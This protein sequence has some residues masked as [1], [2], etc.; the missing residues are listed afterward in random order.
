MLICSVVDGDIGLNMDGAI[1]QD[2]QLLRRI[3]I[4][5]SESATL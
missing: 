4:L 3:H 5:N 2:H 1:T